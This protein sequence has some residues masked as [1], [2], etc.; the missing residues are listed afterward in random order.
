MQYHCVVTELFRP[1]VGESP[2]VLSRTAATTFPIDATVASVQQLGRLVHQYCTQYQGPPV[3]IC[4][5]SSLLC[6]AFAAMPH[7]NNPD[8]AFYFCICIKFLGEMVESF[9]VA[10]FILQAIYKSAA[11]K[12]TALPPEAQAVFDRHDG[13]LNRVRNVK[14]IESSYP[15]DLDLSRT[16]LEGSRLSNLIK[17]ADEMMLDDSLTKD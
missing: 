10:R 15:V 7:L 5:L 11:R 14:E 1:F 6:V 8:W 9:P 17:S 2:R 4:L 13:S 16:D 3:P 12:N